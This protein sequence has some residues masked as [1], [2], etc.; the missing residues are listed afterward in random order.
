MKLVRPILMVVVSIGI[1]I[2]ILNTDFIATL[3]LVSA[4]LG[5]ATWGYSSKEVIQIVKSKF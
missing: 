1:L 4:L 3:C 5:V 2:S